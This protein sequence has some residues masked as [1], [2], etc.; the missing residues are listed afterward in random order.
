MDGSGHLPER[1]W[2]RITLASLSGNLRTLLDQHV[3]HAAERRERAKWMREVIARRLD[4]KQAAALPKGEPR[5]FIEVVCSDSRVVPPWNDQP[6][7]AVVVTLPM[8]GE[9]ISEHFPYGQVEKI[10][11]YIDGIVV[12]GHGDCGACKEA[13]KVKRALASGQDHPYGGSPALRALTANVEADC[14]SNVSIQMGRL[15]DRLANRLK[16]FHV[17]IIGIMNHLFA[18]PHEPVYSEC[19][20]PLRDGFGDSAKAEDTIATWKGILARRNGMLHEAAPRSQHPSV[21]WLTGLS[22]PDLLLRGIG[23][24]HEWTSD[25]RKDLI[26]KVGWQHPED[27]SA[28]GSALYILLHDCV[29][30]VV[31]TATGEGELRRKMK[32]FVDQP[33][34]AAYLDGR[35]ETQ[36]VGLIVDPLGVLDMGNIFTCQRS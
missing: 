27:P 15:Q 12:Q 30:Q 29:R 35:P 17:P 23:S 3:S 34:I 26:F 6:E 14:E 7:H 20:P 28:A 25:R 10:L 9:S 19:G 13:T 32:C 36:L 2:D 22:L 8:A 11:P 24:E 16:E 1:R 33:E 18:G 31:F 5:I 4:G 21:L